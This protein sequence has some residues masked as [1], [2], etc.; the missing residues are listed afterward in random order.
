MI[1]HVGVTGSRYGM[2]DRQMDAMHKI[3]YKVSQ[4]SEERPWLHHGDCLGADYETAVW[5]AHLGYLTVSVPPLNDSYRGFH[6][7]DEILEPDE[8]LTRDRAIVDAVDLLI[9]FPA[10]D[11][12]KPGSGT[13]Y[14]I[15]YALSIPTKKVLVVGPRRLT[16]DRMG[17]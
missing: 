11:K 4:L 15:N 12:E 9:G 1:T 13:W 2:N 3:L 7:S 14:T 5:A 17:V 6:E 8:Y 10:T 16:L